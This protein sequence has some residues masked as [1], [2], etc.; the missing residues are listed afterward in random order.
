MSGRRALVIGL[1][2][3]IGQTYQEFTT[4]TLCLSEESWLKHGLVEAQLL[5]TAITGKSLTLSNSQ[6]LH[7][8]R[9]DSHSNTLNNC[10]DRT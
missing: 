4:E 2:A 9:D 6:F 1:R 10:R 5:S 8:Y 3:S 7:L